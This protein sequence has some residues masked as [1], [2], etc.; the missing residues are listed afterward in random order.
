MSVEGITSFQEIANSPTVYVVVLILG[1]SVFLIILKKLISMLKLKGISDFVEHSSAII[2]FIDAPKWPLILGTSLVF[3]GIIVLLVG[4]SNGGIIQKL[5]GALFSEFGF[6]FIIAFVVHMTVDL[7]AKIEGEKKVSKGILSYIYGNG[8]D[9][10]LFRFVE[11]N[12]F[13]NAFY[14]TDAHL[15]Y[16]FIDIQDDKILMLQTFS[17]RL[18]NVSNKKVNYPIESRIEKTSKTCENLWGSDVRLGIFKICIDGK[19][20]NETE[21]NDADVN[22]EDSDK[23]KIFEHCVEIEPGG[24][25][26]ITTFKYHEKFTRDCELW[27]S[28]KSC[29][30]L[31]GKI[32]WGKNIP[33]KL[34]IDPVHCLDEFH[35]F[36]EV[37][38]DITF[39][40]KDPLVPDNGVYFWWEKVD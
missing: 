22:R 38:G 34:N 40:M 7:H 6:A 24:S 14:R 10:R 5:T 23:F 3:V 16:N 21:L 17:Y 2:S 1:A 33:I 9:D 26:E 39:I 27:R 30:G 8:F 37:P 35:F 11:T 18:N 25:I 20:L 36:S 12:I 31:N 29:N 32:R 19:D 15:E 28:I 4:P 13:N